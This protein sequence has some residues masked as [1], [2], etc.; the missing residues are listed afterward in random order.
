MIYADETNKQVALVSDE[1]TLLF[2]NLNQATSAAIQA[3]EEFID[4]KNRYYFEWI[5]TP[6][7]LI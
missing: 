5:D 6:A 4:Q 7:L 2:D 3:H 1:V